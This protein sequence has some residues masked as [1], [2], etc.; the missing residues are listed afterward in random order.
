VKLEQRSW[1]SS[2]AEGNEV[3]QN[4]VVSRLQKDG[5]PFLLRLPLHRG[6]SED[7]D[8]EQFTFEDGKAYVLNVLKHIFHPTVEGFASLPPFLL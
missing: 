1:S 6:N 3:G 5:S 2:T 7:D 4:F 8:E